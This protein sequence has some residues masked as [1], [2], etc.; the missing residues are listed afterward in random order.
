M[1]DFRIY[2]TALLEE[3]VLDLY[4]TPFSIDNKGNSY[5]REVIESEEENINITK[6]G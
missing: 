5:A 2:A 4:H 1:S 6:T 3:D